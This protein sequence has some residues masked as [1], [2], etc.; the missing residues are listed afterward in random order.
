MPKR[1]EVRKDNYHLLRESGFNSFEA[2]KY[3]DRSQS[4]VSTLC[5]IKK[6]NEVEVEKRIIKILEK[7]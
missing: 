4:L 1:K 2:D 5:N 7:S 3:K 6:N